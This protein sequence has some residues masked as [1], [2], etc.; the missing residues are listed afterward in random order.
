MKKLLVTG[1]LMFMALLPETRLMKTI[2][3]D[4]KTLTQIPRY[5]VEDGKAYVLDE[6]SI[7]LEETG[8]ERAESA[9]VVTTSKKVE[10]L[11]DNDLE[12]IEKTISYDGITC[13]LLYVIYEVTKEEEDGLPVQYSAVCTYGGLKKYGESYPSAWQAIVWYDAYQ[14]MEKP[15]TVTV[16]ESK[17]YTDFFAVKSIRQVEAQ[18]EDETD[19]PFFPKPEIKQSIVKKTPP[20][21]GKEN[22]KSIDFSVPLAVAA[23]LGTGAA[24]PFLFF[25]HSLTVPLFAWKKGEKYRYIGQVRLRKEETAYVA[26]LT[27]RLLGRAELPVFM[28]KL[29]DRVR[30]GAKTDRLQVRCPDGKRLL[31]ICEKEVRFTLERE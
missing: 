25:F 22:K 15:K 12:R 8:R 31:L 26:Y 7:L 16:K 28:M 30:R 10:E 13:S 19:A 14:T 20:D 21:K 6:T 2:P 18:N 5:I 9:E 17:E 3:L 1:C 27:S 11:P 24:F 29:P 4:A 23:A